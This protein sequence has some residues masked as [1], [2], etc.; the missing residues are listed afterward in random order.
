VTNGSLLSK[1]DARCAQP[2]RAVCWL[3][4]YLKS[5]VSFLTSHVCEFQYAINRIYHCA[6]VGSLRTCINISC[7]TDVVHTE[8]LSSAPAASYRRSGPRIMPRLD[9]YRGHWMCGAE[10]KL[11]HREPGRCNIKTSFVACYTRA[12]VNSSTANQS[13]MRGICGLMSRI[14]RLRCASGLCVCVCVCVIA[15]NGSDCHYHFLNLHTLV[16]GCLPSEIF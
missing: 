15:A 4:R 14:L 1:S 16:V 8:R 13:Y 2:Q 11:E 7:Y 10:R 12:S 6:F 5:S 3:A 9:V